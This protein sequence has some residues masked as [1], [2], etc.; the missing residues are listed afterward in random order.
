MSS[1]K[2]TIKEVA[3]KAGV[4]I[5]T[6]SRFLNKFPLKEE[7]RQRVESAVKELNYQPSLYARRL[8]GGHLDTFGLIIP[9]YEGIFYSFY[10]LEIIREVAAVSSEKGID[11]HLNVFWNKDSFKTSLVDGVIMA[12]VIGNEAQM[13]RLLKEEIPLIVINHK[14]ED[15]QVSFVAINNFKGAYEATEFLIQHG[16]KKI[17]H[18]AGDLRVQCADDRFQGYKAALEKGGIRVNKDYIKVTNFSRKEAREKLEEIVSF[19]DMPTAIFC[20]SD[21]IASEVLNFSEEKRIKV[22]EQLSVIG[23]DD[24]PHCLYGN[25]ML[26]TVRQPL[27]TMVNRAVGILRDNIAGRGGPQRVELDTELII[28]DT[29]NFL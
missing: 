28:R 4:S 16:H 14:V 22:P 17:A 24:N 15:P 13:K 6:V 3:K 29:V 10:A 26:T 25:L 21:E 7:N 18:L 20:C 5:A 11:L 8:A 2:I 19:G 23:F 12:D 9:G 1:S 27:K